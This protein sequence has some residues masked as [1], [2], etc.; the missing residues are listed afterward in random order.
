MKT[1]TIYTWDHDTQTWHEEAEDVPLWGLRAWIRRL[2]HDG[3]S[4]VSILIERDG[5]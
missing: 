3:W 2:R 1:Y 5:L 4:S